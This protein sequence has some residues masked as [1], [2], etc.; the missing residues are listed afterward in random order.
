MSGPAAPP[1]PTGQLPWLPIPTSTHTSVGPALEALR[2]LHPIPGV[3]PALGGSPQLCLQPLQ[4][5]GDSWETK[6]TQKKISR[7]KR[8]KK[9]TEK[10]G[11]KVTKV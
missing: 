3:L 7:L 11:S 10:Q 5:L 1:H 4:L 9:I 2:R 6:I 8:G